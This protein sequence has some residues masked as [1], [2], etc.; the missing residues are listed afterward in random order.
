MYIN[1]IEIFG[2][3]KWS[4]VKMNFHQHLQIFQGE[5]ESGK[6]TLRSFIQHILFGFPKKIGG[7]Y[8]YEPLVSGVMG[9]RVWI[10]NTDEGSLFIERTI[11]N[12]KPCFN[13]ETSSGKILSEERWKELL[14]QIDEKKYVKVFGFN[15]EQLD[16]FHFSSMEEIDQFL[17]SVSVTGSEEW[18]KLSKTLQKQAE[19]IFT[20]KAVKKII[21]LQLQQLDLQ[22]VRIEELAQNNEVYEETLKKSEEMKQEIQRHSKKIQQTQEEERKLRLL[23]SHWSS[24]ERW[25]EIQ[26]KI[27]CN[28]NDTWNPEWKYEL[29]RNH[30]DFEWN[31][32]Q[33][34]DLQN[35]YQLWKQIQQSEQFLRDDTRWSQLLN[36][37]L[38]EDEIEEKILVSKKLKIELNECKHNIQKE[39]ELWNIHHERLPMV[40]NQQDI[41]LISKTIQ[42]EKLLKL[43]LVELETQIKRLK[44]EQEKIEKH[45]QKN[46]FKS[47]FVMN[48]YLLNFSAI[49]TIFL[50]LLLIST[51]FYKGIGVTIGIVIGLATWL[52]GKQSLKNNQ[53]MDY[54]SNRLDEITSELEECTV[55]REKIRNDCE[56]ISQ[57]IFAWEKEYGY[58]DSNI[59]LEQLCKG[60][61]LKSLR[62]FVQQTQEKE[63][64]L[65]QIEK[66]LKQ[67][68]I[69]WRW[70]FEVRKENIPNTMEMEWKTVKKIIQEVQNSYQ[71]ELL[72]M[73]EG[74][75]LQEQLQQLQCEQQSLEKQK[76]ILLKNAKVQNDEEFYQQE[77]KYERYCLLLQQYKQL[78]QQ[79]VPYLEELEEF[80]H[81]SYLEE[82]IEQTHQ[83]LMILFQK[84]QQLLE[85]QARLFQQI[86]QLETDGTYHEQ[87]IQFELLKSEVEEQLLEWA[88]SL[89]A[90]KWILESLQK[91]LPTQSDEMIEEAS[92]YFNRL[93]Q[94]RYQSI[95]IQTM[96]I[97]VQNQFGNW[98]FASELSRGTLD[99]LLV[100]IRL[101]FINNISSKIT[102]PV[103]IDDGFVNFDSERKQI[104]LQ[105]IKEISS[106]VQVI[107][108]SLEDEP[109][110][111][112]E[113]QG[114]VIR[115]QR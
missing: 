47:P 115:L 6:S 69:N 109:F 33:I 70:I 82:K 8:P 22:M 19:S 99:Q 32:Q 52:F 26:Y 101:A 113:T 14:S 88:S 74:L 75:K 80:P 35:R 111:M 72:E 58:F 17:Y 59:T 63:M 53:F 28:Q 37:S 13:C 21:N 48:N 104:M 76:S 23:Q 105:L 89:Y 62:Y 57:K 46:H 24:Y 94:G 3:G 5:N 40:L 93:T 15:K 96:K 66:E 65:S 68:Q 67:L 4:N 16:Q 92:H 107:Y 84:N 20:P 81:L 34:Q 42:N 50:S 45:S 112:S 106:K 60:D 78:E 49:V 11:K 38:M 61:V 64:M 100:S 25:K 31:K 7:K 77:A 97:A 10:D 90:S 79:L 114:N 83:S 12:G 85:E 9:G 87:V 1:Q 95:R 103:L 41:A 71:K 56:E 73:N 54:F 27:H 102:L 43:E 36:I 39:E 29:E 110:R 30:L 44:L 2:Y 18:M 55:K 86:Q 98:L 91:Q 51:P 108:F